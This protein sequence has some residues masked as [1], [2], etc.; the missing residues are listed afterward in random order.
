MPVTLAQAKLNAVDDIQLAVIDEFRKSSWLLDNLTFDDVVSPV[1]GGG[2]LTYGYQRAITQRTAAF[3]AI[4]AEYTPTEV[5]KQRFTVDLKPLGGSFQ[6]DRVLARVG[7]ATVSE[8]AFQLRALVAAARAFF[9]NQFINADSAVDAN[10]FDG[11]SVA[12]KGSSTEYNADSVDDWTVIDTQ[13]EALHAVQKINA[14]LGLMDGPPDAILVNNVAKPW[15]T[16]IAALSGQLRS[17]Q[18]AFGRNVELF[19]DIPIIDLGAR[20]GTNNPVIAQYAGTNETQVVTVD[21]TSGTFSLTWSGQTT[22]AIAEA[23]TAAAVQ[24]A[25]EA[26]SNID[27]GD[28]SVAGSAGGPFT[29]TFTGQYAGV[30]VPLMTATNI[31]LAGGGTTVVVTAGTAGGGG[32][33]TGQIGLTDLYAVRLG[34]DGVHGV[35]MAGAPLIQTWLP[36]FTTAGAVKTGEAEMGPVAPVLKATKAASV[37]RNIKVA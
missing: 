9:A 20:D 27:V 7:P 10:G 24:S 2:T 3:R 6:I 11:L 34:L 14:W 21:A 32:T 30:N 5:T 17:A 16:L 8:V 35:S 25:L 26:L 4:N 1:G 15:F 13:I 28:V 29:V 31:N 22:A 33:G 23:A 19:R 37:Y 36:D 12:L 18:D